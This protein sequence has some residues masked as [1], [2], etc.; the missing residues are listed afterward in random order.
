MVFRLCWSA[1]FRRLSFRLCSTLMERIS[2]LPPSSRSSRSSSSS[3]TTTT[4]TPTSTATGTTLKTTAA[5]MTTT[6]Q[7]TIK[8]TTSVGVSRSTSSIVN[9]LGSVS[10]DC[11]AT[12]LH[13]A[14]HIEPAD[15]VNPADSLEGLTLSSHTMFNSAHSH[16][17]N[18]NPSDRSLVGHSLDRSVR[19]LD[20]L[21]AHADYIE[22]AEPAD[23]DYGLSDD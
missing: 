19:T 23:S 2:G 15:N 8:T 21:L 11:S 17:A 10:I 4:T 16:N 9:Q 18:A 5:G 13:F 7:T 14:D 3:T 20:D 1:F 6:V 12:S 22:A